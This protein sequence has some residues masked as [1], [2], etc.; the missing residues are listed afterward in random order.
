MVAYQ[1]LSGLHAPAVVDP[2]HPNLVG[3]H[4]RLE[5]T[6][7]ALAARASARRLCDKVEQLFL[8][9]GATVEVWAQ[10]QAPLIEDAPG[11]EAAAEAPVQLRVS[12]HEEAPQRDPHPATMAAFFVTFTLAPW[13]E[14]ETLAESVTVRDDRGVTLAEDRF[15]ARVVTSNGAAVWAGNALADRL[16]RPEAEHVTRDAAWKQLSA[17]LYQQLSQ[18]VVNAAVQQRLRQEAAARQTDGRAP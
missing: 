16:W 9:Q 3:V 13:M 14:T 1:P 10:G 6:S 4:L 17:D 5:C 11:A 2:T 15:E 12:L 8:T 7:E 18:H